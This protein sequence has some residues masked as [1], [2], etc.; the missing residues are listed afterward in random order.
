MSEGTPRFAWERVIR[1][2]GL[3]PTVMAV[4]LM[5]ATF[6]DTRA[7]T[8]IHPSH[9]RLAKGICVSERT[10]GAAIS[11]LIELGFLR[12]EQRANRHTKQATVYTLTLP[13]DRKP[14]DIDREV[15]RKS[16]VDVDQ[17]QAS[18]R[19]TLPVEARFRPQAHVSTSLLLSSN[20]AKP[21]VLLSSL[22]EPTAASAEDV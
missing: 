22:G 14:G 2:A 19:S 20:T 1:E 6:A 10:I 12:V 7:G 13:V 18:S 17:K 4:A 15:D 8:S 5:A 16:D 9:A 3:R 21:L 11:T